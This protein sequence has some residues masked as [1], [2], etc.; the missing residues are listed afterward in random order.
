MLAAT[1]HLP[2]ERLREPAVAPARSWR[3]RA[4][5]RSIATSGAWRP[6]AATQ[7]AR[8]PWLRLVAR[9]PRSPTI[10]FPKT[11]GWPPPADLGSAS[12][13]RLRQT[14]Q[15]ATAGARPPARTFEPGARQGCPSSRDRTR[16]E[17]RLREAVRHPSPTPGRGL[18]STDGHRL[19]GSP[20]GARRPRTGPDR[21]RRRAG[22]GGRCHMR[23]W[24]DDRPSSA[25]S[26]AAGPRN[27]GSARPAWRDRSCVRRRCRGV[28]D[29]RR[30]PVRHAT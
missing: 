22:S 27:A 28:W 4:P 17:G 29:R 6:R 14:R 12:R 15:P 13:H 30:T 24:S 20:A 16:S 1:G 10:G 7:L 26:R 18:P 21:R 19:P 8:A 2:G 9:R 5:A 3:L 25:S 23:S 11:T